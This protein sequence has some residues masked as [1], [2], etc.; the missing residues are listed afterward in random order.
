M[1]TGPAPAPAGGIDLA[2]GFRFVPEDPDW[3]KKVLIGGVFMLLSGLLIGAVFVAG[4]GVRL[5][6]NSARGEPRP[7]PEWDDLGGMVGDGLRAVALYLVYALP[8]VIVPMAFAIVV[9]M[10][11]AGLSGPGNRGASEA[12]G[13]LAA[14]GVMGLY[15]L[16]AVA[17]L[18]LGL[19]VPAA[20]ARFVMLERLGAGFEVRENFAFIRR[21]LPNYAMAL[22]LYLLASFAAQ[23]G[24][25]LCCVG[26]FPASFWAFC[27][28]CWALG[29]VV[30][31]DP[32]LAPRSRPTA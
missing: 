9:A 14:M 18:A 13:A 7:L 27:I 2:R 24:I 15:A 20:L 23:L 6:R 26:F 28:L 12:F 4:Y 10:A 30:R 21:N 3:I 16:M 31:R 32:L 25:V 5:I 1:S 8:V 22:L 17:M 11:S 19:Y 29:E